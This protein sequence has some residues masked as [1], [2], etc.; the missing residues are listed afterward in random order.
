M[1]NSECQDASHHRA[2]WRL[3]GV[4]ERSMTCRSKPTL[5]QADRPRQQE[6][7]RLQEKVIEAH[8]TGT[9]D[10]DHPGVGGDG[11]DAS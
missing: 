4:N 9:V 1:D 11:R 10:A 8:D 6:S 7:G 2:S 3:P 5:R